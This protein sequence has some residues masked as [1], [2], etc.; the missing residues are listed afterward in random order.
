M[1]HT[2]QED[3][4]SAATLGKEGRRSVPLLNSIAVE[5]DI[6]E[7][8][9]EAGPSGGEGER[10]LEGDAEAVRQREQVLHAAAR[11]AVENVRK[12]GR[13]EAAEKQAARKNGGVSAPERLRDRAHNEAVLREAAIRGSQQ[14]LGEELGGEGRGGEAEAGAEAEPREERGNRG[15]GRERGGGRRGAALLTP[16]QR[17]E[18]RLLSSRVRNSTTSFLESEENKRLQTMNANRWENR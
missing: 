2:S 11:Q 13:E 6:E 14:R 4:A 16:R 8:G 12:R 3:S 15:S 1:A 9:P 10:A 18:K 7:G 17:I 5:R